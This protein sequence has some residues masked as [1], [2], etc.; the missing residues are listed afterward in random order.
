MGQKNTV[1]IENTDK[2]ITDLANPFI[3]K[4]LRIG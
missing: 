3:S 2:N 4:I 1:T